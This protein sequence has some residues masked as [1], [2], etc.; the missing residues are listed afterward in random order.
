FCPAN[1]TAAHPTLDPIGSL[2]LGVSLAPRA[3]AQLRVL[4][5]LVT[6]RKWAI[7]LV[8]R[9]LD[10]P[11]A[12]TA[13]RPRETLHPIGHGEVPPGTPEPYFVF[14]DDGRTLTVRTPFTPRPFDH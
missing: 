10:V 13:E 1:D 8:A 5:G 9:H 7:D 3:S 2:L 6:D 11:A 12:V 14:S 4:I